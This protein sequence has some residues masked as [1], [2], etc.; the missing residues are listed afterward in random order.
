MLCETLFERIC[1]V[2][3]ISLHLLKID[4]KFGCQNGTNKIK[5][6]INMRFLYIWGD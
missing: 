6:R 3:K 1:N 5:N 2:K 4:V